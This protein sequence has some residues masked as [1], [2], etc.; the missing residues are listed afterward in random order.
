MV[1]GGTVIVRE[2]GR[3]ACSSARPSPRRPPPRERSRPPI[4]L[5]DFEGESYGDWT[6]E[7]QAF[8]TR[9]STGASG[10]EQHLRGFRARDWSTPGPAATRRG[11][12]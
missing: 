9:P 6:A 2:A 4:V 11:A 7:G 3:A 8:G 1:S 12:S 10:P 5:A